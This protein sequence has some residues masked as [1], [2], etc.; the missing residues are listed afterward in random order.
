MHFACILA[1]DHR[2]AF[3]KLRECSNNHNHQ[4]A[5]EQMI[6]FQ[7]PVAVGIDCF[8]PERADGSNPAI[9][10]S[11]VLEELEYQFRDLASCD[12]P[13]MI[14]LGLPVAQSGIH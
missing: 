6:Q 10:N 7:S 9:A 3:V 5:V 8:E 4:H 13:E 1:R 14:F 12:S 2:Q 11:S